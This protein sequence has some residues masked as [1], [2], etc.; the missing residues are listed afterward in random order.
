[1]VFA[2]R[3]QNGWRFLVPPPCQEPLQKSQGQ[4][5]KWSVTTGANLDVVGRGSSQQD[6]EGVDAW[7]KKRESWACL[8]QRQ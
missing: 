8:I 5:R 4:H 7:Q 3:P 6:K 2:Q 1:M